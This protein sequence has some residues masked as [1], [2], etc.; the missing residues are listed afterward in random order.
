MTT[1]TLPP[2]RPA[3][4]HKRRPLEQFL[5]PFLRHACE[6]RLPIECLGTFECDGAPYAL[7]RFV[8]RSPGIDDSPM[9]IAVFAGIHGDEPSGIYACADFLKLL[10]EHPILAR[11]YEVHVYPVCNPTGCEDGTR[12]S[13]RGFD[14]NRE[15]W[16]NSAQPEVRLIER[17]LERQQY[18]GLISLH[19]DDT[20]AGL[21]GFV[22]GNTLTE[23]LLRPALAAA[24]LALPID[25]ADCIDGFHAVNGI[26]TSCYGG[27]LSAPPG[28]RPAPFEIILESPERAPAG[29]QRQAFVF[30][31]AEILRHYRRLIAYA[32]N[33]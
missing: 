5:E 21:Y 29:L 28:S 2:T 31:L 12:H 19:S 6:A 14:L 4:A 8:H 27:I 16:R 7:R 18:C 17:E 3:R 23:H 20:C 9:K 1:P 33:I 24:E 11:G 30:A 13:R 15:F 32:A 10:H 25:G 22:R 26:I